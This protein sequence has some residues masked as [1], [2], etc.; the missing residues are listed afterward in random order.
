VTVVRGTSLFDMNSA[1]L[2]VIDG[3]NY[4]VKCFAKAGGQ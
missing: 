1:R 4:D 2:T 3:R